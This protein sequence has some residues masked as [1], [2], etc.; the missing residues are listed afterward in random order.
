VYDITYIGAEQNTAAYTAAI[1]NGIGGD[2]EPLVFV[3]VTSGPD[4]SQLRELAD[5]ISWYYLD[6][7]PGGSD[8]YIEGSE[9]NLPYTASGTVEEGSLLT[10]RSFITAAAAAATE[11]WTSNKPLPSITLSHPGSSK[12]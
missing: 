10:V 12:L 3:I 5:W 1:H 8:G 9:E 4:K 11:G 6:S 2:D 7:G